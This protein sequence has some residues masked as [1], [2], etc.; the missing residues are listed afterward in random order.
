MPAPVVRSRSPRSC[1]R[2]LQPRCASAQAAVRPAKPAPTISA[3]RL[4]MVAC[5]WRQDY[6]HGCE[7][8]EASPSGGFIHGPSAPF[9]R[10]RER[11]RQGRKILR[12]RVRSQTHRARRFGYRLGDLYER[13]HD[14]SRP[15]QFLD[16]RRHR[17]LGPEKSQRLSSAR[18]ISASRSTISPRR[19]SASRRT[20]ANSSSISATNVTAISSASSRT[21]TA[22]SSIFPRTAGRARIVTGRS[23]AARYRHP[24]GREAA[25]KQYGRGAG[26][27]AIRGSLRS[28]SA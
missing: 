5:S 26:A 28:P 11:S 18:T 20:A 13:R 22:S 6:Y 15:A 16:R 2:T 7:P 12:D 10:L 14:Q 27:V 24:G 1:T 8:G 25:P 23:D 17:G 21:P 9:R 19:R 4:L 3:C